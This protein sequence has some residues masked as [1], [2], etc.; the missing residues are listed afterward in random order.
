MCVTPHIYILLSV[1]SAARCEHLGVRRHA[2]LMGTFLLLCSNLGARGS[3]AGVAEGR[4][5]PRPLPPPSETAPAHPTLQK[6]TIPP[7]R[8]T[9]GG[10]PPLNLLGHA[11]CGPAAWVGR[12]TSGPHDH[13][14]IQLSPPGLATPGVPSRTAGPPAPS[15]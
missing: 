1:L 3:K 5:S 2:L 10:L 14:P 9:G 7:N 8:A 4:V 11:I 13:Q 15:R 6:G 12:R